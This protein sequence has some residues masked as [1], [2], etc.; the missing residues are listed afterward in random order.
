MK[1]ICKVCKVKISYNKIAIFLIILYNLSY[2]TVIDLFKYYN[3]KFII[4]YNKL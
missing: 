1:Y 2:P 4:K 3:Y